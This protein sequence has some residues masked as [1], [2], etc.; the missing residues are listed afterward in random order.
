M[1]ESQLDNVMQQQFNIDQTQFMTENLKDTGNFIQ[2]S[3]SGFFST[4]G[5][6]FLRPKLFFFYFHKL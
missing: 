2:V 5:R 4:V 3:H 1:Y 6:G